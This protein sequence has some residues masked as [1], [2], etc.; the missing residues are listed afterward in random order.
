MKIQ[1]ICEDC[2]SIAEFIPRRK[3]ERVGIRTINKNFRVG[4]NWKSDVI[5]RIQ[6]DFVEALGMAASDEERR[7]I[8]EEGIPR[9]AFAEPVDFD[10]SFTCR[11][12]GNRITLN[13]FQLIDYIGF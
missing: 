9:N 3:K 11:G 13:D 12:C 2:N 1:V 10:V 5:D 6:M 4:V 8:L 7:A